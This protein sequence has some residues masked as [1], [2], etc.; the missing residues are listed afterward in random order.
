MDK[1]DRI[2]RLAC[3]RSG[4]GGNG[5]TTPGSNS[6][7]LHL[8]EKQIIMSGRDG[9]QYMPEYAAWTAIGLETKCRGD[10]ATQMLGII[11]H[12]VHVPNP[13]VTLNKWYTSI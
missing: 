8:L 4:T 9:S 12:D 11:P 2:A 5:P 10:R 6:T 7:C 1:T 13:Y 3:W